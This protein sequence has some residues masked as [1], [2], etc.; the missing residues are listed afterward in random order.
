MSVHYKLLS[1]TIYESAESSSQ[2]DGRQR[3]IT[4]HLLV[5]SVIN[6]ERGIAVIVPWRNNTAC[7]DCPR[8]RHVIYQQRKHDELRKLHAFATSQALM[9]K[10]RCERPQLRYDQ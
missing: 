6:E 10:R 7:R 4:K 3:F 9:S 1:I 5:F 2:C 8:L